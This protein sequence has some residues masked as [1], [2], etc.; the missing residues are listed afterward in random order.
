MPVQIQFAGRRRRAPGVEQSFCS[1]ERQAFRDQLGLGD[2]DRQLGK[3]IRIGLPRIV[4]HGVDR[5]GGG[6]HQ[7]FGSGGVGGD[8]AYGRKDERIFRRRVASECEAGRA[9]SRT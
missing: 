1:R 4:D 9:F 3:R 5:G 2:G 8:I 7:R 6:E